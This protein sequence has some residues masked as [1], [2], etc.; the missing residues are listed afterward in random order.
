MRDR[1]NRPTHEQKPGSETDR[2]LNSIDIFDSHSSCTQA[3]E[4]E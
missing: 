4:Q 3:H 1:M 2:E